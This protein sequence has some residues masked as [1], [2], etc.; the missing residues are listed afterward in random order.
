MCTNIL[1]EHVMYALDVKKQHLEIIL[2]MM[3]VMKIDPKVKN[4]LLKQLSMI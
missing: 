4:L 2:F 3:C 1:Y